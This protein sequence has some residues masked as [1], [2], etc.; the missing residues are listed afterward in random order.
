MTNLISIAITALILSGLICALMCGLIKRT[1]KAIE[2]QKWCA[3][4]KNEDSTKCD[5]CD[6]YEFWEERE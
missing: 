6:G 2:Q 5:D 3:D 1:E 4:C